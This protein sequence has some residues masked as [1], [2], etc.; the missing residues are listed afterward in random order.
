[1]IGLPY[2]F[3]VNFGKLPLKVEIFLSLKA[4]LLN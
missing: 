1:L 2:Y 4:L 3:V